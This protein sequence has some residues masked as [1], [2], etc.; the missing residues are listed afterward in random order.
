MGKQSGHCARYRQIA[1]LVIAG[2]FEHRDAKIA[3]PIY[4]QHLL[5]LEMGIERRSTYVGAIEDVLDRHILIA[6]LK[7]QLDQGAR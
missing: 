6:F 5:A 3:R 7:H 4:E 1:W 2:Q